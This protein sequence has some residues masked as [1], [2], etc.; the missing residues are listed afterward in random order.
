MMKKFERT[1]DTISTLVNL[2]RK[3]IR[4]KKFEPDDELRK[5]IF[6]NVSIANREFRLEY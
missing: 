4:T 5:A 1:K 2:I 3:S 6:Q